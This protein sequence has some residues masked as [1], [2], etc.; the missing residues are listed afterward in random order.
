MLTLAHHFER[1]SGMS[2]DDTASRRPSKS[3]DNPK[4]I[5]NEV[6][7]GRIEPE[8]ATTHTT[9]QHLNS[10]EEFQRR[11]AGFEDPTRKLWDE[12]WFR[13]QAD[14]CWP[15]GTTLERR[16]T[17]ISGVAAYLN[18]I[19]EIKP[20]IETFT[21]ADF[22]MPTGLEI[23]E[24]CREY[25]RFEWVLRESARYMA[26]LR[27]GGFPSP[28]LD[29]THSPYVAAY[30]AFSR[31]R[32]DGAVAIYAYRERPVNFKVGGSDN[33]QIISFGPNIKTHKRHF[34]QQSRYTACVRFKDGQ[35]HF[36]PH[37]GVFGIRDNLQQDQLWK[38]TVPA[39]ERQKALRYFDKFNLNEF[40]LFD[41]EE[42]LLEML[43]ARVIDLRE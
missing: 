41:S 31:A 33:P 43:A 3:D 12:V 29:W 13:G 10:W 24:T 5:L 14:A 8:E 38:M 39:A 17:K 19:A 21:G 40:T 30:F 20:A 4:P 23:S 22:H 26:H 34:R 11:V 25:D 6:G 15:L 28:L 2:V 1:D 27:H 7:V 37:D 42:G 16:T 35:W 18:L 9:I 36:A 32:R